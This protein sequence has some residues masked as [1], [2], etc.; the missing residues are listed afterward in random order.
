VRAIAKQ[1][2]RSLTPDEAE[3]V[4][5]KTWSVTSPT[6]RKGTI[7]DWRNHFEPEHKTA[8]RELAGQALIELGYEKDMDW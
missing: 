4:A 7:G 6:F 3:G 1:V 5:R 8:F 2:G